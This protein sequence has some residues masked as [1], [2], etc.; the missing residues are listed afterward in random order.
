MARKRVGTR[1]VYRCHNDF[2]HI[3]GDNGLVKMYP[4]ITDLG[5]AQR[6]DGPGPLLHPIQP[7]DCHAPE[8][9]L[10]VGWSYSADMW[11][12][13][14][15]VWELLTGRSLFKQDDPSSY[16]AVKHLA[17]MIAILSPIPPGLVQREKAM[18][19]WRWGPQVLNRDGQLCGSAAEF[20]GGPFFAE[21]GT[22]TGN[23]LVPHD[24]IWE[25]DV[26]SCIPREEVDCFFRFMRRMLCW[27]PEDRATARELKSDPWLGDDTDD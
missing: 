21:D 16:S 26:P 10:G 9:L 18:R 23:H 19:E 15:V 1:T 4:K 12:F 3:Q 13:G 27:L 6:G 8:V 11:N 25:N 20:F 14:I 5:L 2:G 7:N 24:R 22:F 17:D